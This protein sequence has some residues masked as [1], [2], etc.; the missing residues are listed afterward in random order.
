MNRALLKSDAKAAMSMT[1]PHPVLVTIV[2]LVIVYIIE[3]IVSSVSGIGTL[4]GS[5]ASDP[6]AAEAVAALMMVPTFFLSILASLLTSVLMAGYYGYSLRVINHHP[7]NI[8]DLFGYLRFFLKIWGL[9]IVINLFTS[10]WTLLFIIPGIVASYRYSMAFY[11]L[12]ENP[13]KGIMECIEESKAM[14]NGYKIEKFVLDL[15]FIP[16]WLLT[17]VTCGIATI[18][19]TP[20]TSI[21]AAAFYNTLKYGQSSCQPFGYQQGFD[22]GGFQQEYDYNTYQQNGYQQNF[23]Q[24]GYS[25]NGYQQDNNPDHT[26]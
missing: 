22:Q 6:E 17:A 24:Q 11:I 9:S 20:Y 16:W 13:E 8:S 1:S 12:A 23:D 15:S 19:V 18:Y 26:Q 14:M 5:I 10:L 7:A 4:I 2:Y 21:T 25:Q 3:A